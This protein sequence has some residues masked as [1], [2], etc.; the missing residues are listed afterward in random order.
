[1]AIDFLGTPERKHPPRTPRVEYHLPEE[2]SKK[3]RATPSPTHTA[4]PPTEPHRIDLTPDYYARRRRKRLLLGAL[5]VVT[6]IVVGGLWY[7]LRTPQSPE[8]P[9]VTVT[10][11]PIPQ[12][13]PTPEPTPPAPAQVPAPAPSM[14][15]TLPDTPLAP[16]RGSL[17]RFPGSATI[18][19]VETNGE[20]RR[21][22]TQSV[23]FANGQTMAQI[24]LQLI[25]LINER[26][27]DTRRGDRD[28]TGRVDFDPRVLTQPELTPF[29]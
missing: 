9:I 3:Q 26:W 24:N 21:V 28:V 7:A 10:P 19:L 15:I 14:P 13:T 1:M 29:L 6:L 18:Y 17:I 5:V 23:I 4:A 12:P 16:L 22:V 20:L 27:S 11:E 8:P 25:Y 2:A